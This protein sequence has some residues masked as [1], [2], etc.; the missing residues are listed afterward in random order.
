MLDH[1]LY[2]S[3]KQI[4]RQSKDAIDSPVSWGAEDHAS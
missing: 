4:E 1:W 3:N 2:D